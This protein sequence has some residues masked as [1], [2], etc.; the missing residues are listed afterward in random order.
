MG[1]AEFETLLKQAT[2]LDAAS[3]GAAAVERAVQAR[4]AA[5][6]LNG[7]RDYWG[8]VNASRTELQALIEAVV[9][10]ET[11][12][13]RDREAFAA[14]ARI[15]REDWLPA[16]P[17][18]S[19]RLLSLPCASGEEPY[20]M[21]MALLDTGFPADR[22][23]IDAVDISAQALTQARRGV[24][25]KN[26]FRGTELSYRERYFLPAPNA[27]HVNDRVRQ[28]VR[29]QHGNLFAGDLLAGAA[30]Y[31]MIFCRNLLIYFDRATQDRAVGILWQR[32]AADGVL[33]VGPSET[34]LVLS[35]D[36][37]SAKLPLAFAVRKSGAK[38]RATV[39][40]PAQPARELLP[41]LSPA[42]VARTSRPSAPELRSEG[43]RRTQVA[44]ETPSKEDAGIEAATRLADQGHLAEAAKT[45]EEHIRE[46]GPSAPAFHLMGLIRNAAGNLP[47]AGQ[48]YRKALYLDRH[49]HGTLV[50]LALLLEQQGDTAGAQLMRGRVSRLKKKKSE[51]T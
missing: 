24:Y 35:Y 12:F 15:A 19:L 48:Y 16:H 23:S 40:P 22:Y 21:A 2:G 17:D 28:Q 9:V 34:S 33:F 37:V 6:H 1:D 51:M 3:I 27:D 50:H 38:A 32:L 18:G 39:P 7:T 13:F 29:F 26:S 30:D 46:H 14:L 43:V 41:K 10:P 44:A 31:D 49:H 47:E 42:L 8:L 20:S 45:C 36:F 25:G 4:V 5:C 11:W